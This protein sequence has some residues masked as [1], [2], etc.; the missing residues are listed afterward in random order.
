MP[1]PQAGPRSR[2]PNAAAV[3]SDANGPNP[4]RQLPSNSPSQHPGPKAEYP[5]RDA[6]DDLLEVL[7]EVATE[8]TEREGGEFSDAT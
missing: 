2:T 4:H 3:S 8:S 5:H 1:L 6:L 7:A